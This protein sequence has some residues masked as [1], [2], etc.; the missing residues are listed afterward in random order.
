MGRERTEPR[1]NQEVFGPWPDGV[2]ELVADYLARNTELKDSLNIDLDT[3]PGKVLKRFG[4]VLKL[5]NIPNLTGN[6]RN[7]YVFKRSDGEEFLLITDNRKVVVTQDMAAFTEIYPG[8]WPGASD[9]DENFPLEFETAFDKA[10]MTNGNDFV[11]HFDG[12]QLVVHD[13]NDTPLGITWTTADADDTQTSIQDTA[14]LRAGD[15]TYLGAIIVCTGAV[16]QVNIGIIALVTGFTD[17]TGGGGLE[18]KVSFDA[19][20]FPAVISDGDT[21]QVGVQ[22]PRGRFPRFHF[23]TLFMA[24]TPE[25]QSEVRFSETVDPFE[26][27]IIMA[28][29]NP[30]AWPGLN[31]FTVAENDGDRIWGITPIYR[32]RFIIHKS[33]GLFRIDPDPVATFRVFTVTTE[34][35]SRFPRTFRERDSLMIF[36]GNRRDELADIFETDFTQV[37]DFNRRHSKTLDI[38]RRPNQ[39]FRQRLITS[40]AQFNAGSLSDTLT[41]GGAEIKSRRYNTQ[42]AWLERLNL[43]TNIDLETNPGKLV[44]LG[45]PD[46]NNPADGATTYVSQGWTKA[47]VGSESSD[48]DI[49][50]LSA[51]VGSG[52]TL[53]DTT[54]FPGLLKGS[55]CFYQARIRVSGTGNIFGSIFI[56]GFM[57][58]NVQTANSNSKTNITIGP[59]GSGDV[60]LGLIG[61][62][63]IVN[64]TTTQGVANGALFRLA[65]FQDSVSTKIWVNEVLVFSLVSQA[66]AGNVRS[67]NF[68]SSGNSVA[69]DYWNLHTDFKGNSLNSQGGKISP[70]ALPNTLPITGNLKLLF[71]YKKDLSLN[72]ALYSFGKYSWDVTN[73]SESQLKTS[74]SNDGLAFTAPL[75]IADLGTPGLDNATT[76]DRFLRYEINYS[77]ETGTGRKG[78]SGVISELM[79]GG[80]YLTEPIFV[81]ENIGAFALFLE[82]LLLNG[83]IVNVR[84]IRR[85][86]ISSPAPDSVDQTGWDLALAGS[87]AE[88]FRPI[89]NNTNIGTALGD[90]VPPASRYI[91]LLIEFDPTDARVTPVFDSFIFNWI[92]GETEAL[93]VSAFVFKKKYLLMG[94]EEGFDSNN[95]I[96]CFDSN[97]AFYNWKGLNLNNMFLFNGELFGLRATGRDILQII[98]GLFNDEGAAISAFIQ[99][100]QN[101]LGDI[102]GRNKLR[103]IE[104][105]VDSLNSSILV[106]FKQNN[107]VNFTTLGTLVYDSTGIHKRL[108]FKMGANAKRFT[109]RIENNNVDEDFG[110]IGA[111]VAHILQVS[112]SG[113]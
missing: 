40:T 80:L 26:P 98:P 72:S 23:G 58:L 89:T 99:T 106:L 43:G 1:L 111:I 107:D 47:D 55:A 101:I 66:G 16:N 25:N 93:P 14:L 59:D 9:L 91:Q 77:L 28:P 53:T 5:A 31:Q 113:R 112:R 49:L 3:E 51:A 19:G 102:T 12:V 104:C 81:G 17:N 41:A 20:T 79:A 87:D 38:F 45:W 74:S 68:F 71:D 50:T 64:L 100:K 73:P 84:K 88:G 60:N 15:G 75:N 44:M 48:G 27:E 105:I 13:D 90:I 69:I 96:V 78:V 6:A 57:T 22:I 95:L 7:A 18:G 52:I 32:D 24:G 8:T 29:N 97:R 109:L 36:M 10:W 30:N 83:G 34:I 86:L 33:T 70:I 82:S 110:L 21:F 42:A 56:Q 35:G 65:V 67:V 62:G 92:D 4:S 61:T 2:N 85:S 37:N 94:A 76:K 11:M 103:H 39:I 63:N 108:N 46:W 54:T